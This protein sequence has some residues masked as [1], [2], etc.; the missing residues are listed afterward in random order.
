MCDHPIKTHSQCHLS[1]RYVALKALL[2]FGKSTEH[3]V[4]HTEEWEKE[5]EER[6]VTN[7][8]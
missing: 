6:S 8:E 7:P 3:F 4:Q 2:S 5:Q 1:E